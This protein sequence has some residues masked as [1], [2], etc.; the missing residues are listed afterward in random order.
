MS[1]L[2]RLLL[3]SRIAQ[4]GEIVAVFALALAFIRIGMPLAGSSPIAAQGIV[5]LANVLMLFL[6]WLGLRLRSQG[7]EHLGL[8]FDLGR[9]QIIRAFLRS[10]PVFIA[11]LA[12]FVLA[13][14]LTA[15]VAGVPEPADLSEFDFLRGD[16]LMLVLSLAGVYMVSSFG[17]EVIYRG[18]LITRFAELG[19]STGLARGMAVL[20]GALV[21]GLVHFDWGLAG[22][23]QTAFV[24]VALGASYLLVGRNLWVLVLAHAYLDTALLLQVYVTPG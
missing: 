20:A 7:W 19:S 16:P 1:R 3:R 15:V 6:V 24:G 10:I 8:L 5:W 22:I 18:F 2:G 11:A 13:A 21:F 4:I 14:I 23:V 17:E 12:A 9:R